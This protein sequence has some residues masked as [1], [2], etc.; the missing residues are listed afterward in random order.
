LIGTFNELL[1]LMQCGF[2]NGYVWDLEIGIWAA[3]DAGRSSD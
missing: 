3:G 1:F 2:Q